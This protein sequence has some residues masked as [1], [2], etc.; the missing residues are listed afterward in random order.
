M[1]FFVSVVLVMV[2]VLLGSGVCGFGEEGTAGVL[3]GE[4]YGF[5]TMT[6]LMMRLVVAEL[7]LLFEPA[8]GG[9]GAD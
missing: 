9:V 1:C 8:A 3:P 5:L 2:L 6:G 7:V 4:A